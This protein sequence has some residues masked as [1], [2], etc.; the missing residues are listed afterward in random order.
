MANHRIYL[1][2][3]TNT[4]YWEI[5][6]KHNEL[7]DK[8]E[9][10]NS[11]ILHFRI[12]RLLMFGTKKKLIGIGKEVLKLHGEFL[13][14]NK[15]ACGFAFAPK[16]N[17][18]VDQNKELVFHHFTNNLRFLINTLEDSM[19]LIATNYNRLF[20]YFEGKKNFFIAI[21]AF[22]IGIIGLLLS[23][24]GLFFQLNIIH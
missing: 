20:S 2:E 10:Y 8:W 12:P 4:E 16:Y 18:D 6:K 11:E 9:Q 1:R 7:M 21:S 13:E 14:W 3:D 15:R 5:Y 24:Y 23:T 17:F 22:I 19:V